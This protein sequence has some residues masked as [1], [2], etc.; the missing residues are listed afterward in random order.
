MQQH[1]GG[2]SASD[3]RGRRWCGASAVEPQGV[4]AGAPVP[5][6]LPA[7]AAVSSSSSGSRSRSRSRSC[8]GVWTTRD[9][10]GAGLDRHAHRQYADSPPAAA[11]PAAA[12]IA[13]IAAAT[14]LRC[15]RKEHHVADWSDWSPARFSALTGLEHLPYCW[16]GTCSQVR[17]APQRRSRRIILAGQGSHSQL[18]MQLPARAGLAMAPVPVPTHLGPRA[19]PPRGSSTK[20]NR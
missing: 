3:R 16:R 18:R 11:M 10:C 19:A 7:P 20:S 14:Y 17:L 5:A 8:A 12:A 2:P 15:W 9:C 4:P 13:T 1:P 6:L